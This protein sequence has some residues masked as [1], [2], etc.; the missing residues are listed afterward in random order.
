MKKPGADSFNLGYLDSG[1]EI[2]VTGNKYNVG[3]LLFPTIQSN[4]K[5][6]QQIY[7]FLYQVWCAITLGASIRKPPFTELKA[8]KIAQCRLEASVT[9][10]SLFL[11]FSWWITLVWRAI[12][13]QRSQQ[14]YRFRGFLVH[15]ASDRFC[16][17]SE[18]KPAGR[19]GSNCFL[20]VGS[21]Y[22]NR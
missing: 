9:S 12:V 1:D 2:T 22:K 3:Y 18:V 19:K 7:S 8:P 14:I 4:I 6:K 20:Y 17:F 21:I 11:S 16:E 15:H 10:I 13:I 5:A